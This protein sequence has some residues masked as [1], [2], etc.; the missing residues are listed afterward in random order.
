MK[1]ENLVFA[2]LADLGMAQEVAATAEANTDINGED[3]RK[4]PSF[5]EPGKQN[6]KFPNENELT[7]SAPYYPSPLVGRFKPSD[8]KWTGAI[9]R[10]RELVDKLTLV[11]K[12]NLTTGIGSSLCSGTTRSIPRLGIPSICVND[13]PLGVGNADLVSSFPPGLSVGSSFNKPLAKLRGQAIGKEFR[14]KG[15]PVDLGPCIGPISSLGGRG[16]ESFGYDPYLNGIMGAITVENVQGKGVMANIKH[17]I[18]YEQEKYRNIAEAK[19]FGFGN[20][21]A[22]IS[23]NIDDRTM[24]EVYM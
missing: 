17:F 13:G 7:K 15:I 12:V 23:S 10:A 22:T 21:V 19:K 14:A 16:W 11:E 5:E 9:K 6:I 1:V 2:V 18:G 4:I 8:E 20:I 24:H 3:W